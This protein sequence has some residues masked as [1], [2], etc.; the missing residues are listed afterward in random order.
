MGHV[1]GQDKTHTAERRLH[2]RGVNLYGNSQESKGLKQRYIDGQFSLSGALRLAKISP[3]RCAE[4][5]PNQTDYPPGDGVVQWE[6]QKPLIWRVAACVR[7][8]QMYI[9]DYV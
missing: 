6:L 8:G 2:D 3:M 9:G 7:P 5:I 1:P 4:K